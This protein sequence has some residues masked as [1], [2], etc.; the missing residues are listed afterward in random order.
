MVESS[1]AVANRYRVK[2]IPTLRFLLI[3]ACGSARLIAQPEPEASPPVEGPEVTASQVEILQALYNSIQAKEDEIDRLEQTLAESTNESSRERNA[4]MLNRSDAELAD[5]RQEFV[6]AATGVDV[7]LFVEEEAT[8]FSWEEQLGKLLQPVL[9]ELE[10]ATAESRALAELKEQQAQFEAQRAAA[11]QAEDTLEATLAKVTDEALKTALRQ[12]IT[13]WSQRRTIAENQVNAAQ[14]RIDRMEAVQA[15]LLD[16]S[17]GAIQSFVRTRGLNLLLAALAF[18]ATYFVT[19]MAFAAIRQGIASKKKGELPGRVLALIGQVLSAL[20]A[21]LAV[22]LVFNLRGD[23][24][25]LGIVLILLLGAAWASFKT[26]PGYVESVKLVLNLGT[27]RED[28]CLVFHGLPWKV[29]SLGFSCRLVNERLDGG[30]LRVPVKLLIGQLSRPMGETEQ[31]FPCQKGDWVTLADGRTGEVIAQNPTLVTL[32]ELGGAQCSYATADFL[33]QQPRNL[34]H[35]YRV[36]TRFG[37]DHAHQAIATTSVPQI[38]A[39]T[40]RQR[41]PQTL[42]TD[43][44]R[45][46]RVDFA[47]ATS[48]ALEY[49]VE[50]DLTG[51]AANFYEDAGFALQRILVEV[52]QEHQWKIPFTQL[53]LHQAH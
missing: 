4:A 7:S 25:L 6:E 52:C 17:T 24:F 19:K 43:A 32:R 37:I 28:E 2:L 34:S 3:L 5:L 10:D 35:G 48:S 45:R 49:E 44:I 1:A 41:L 20:L 33:K 22:I 16:S 12:Q 40:L 9:S 31:L 13:V 51:S 47:C 36:E 50:V 18:A 39:E 30:F 53:T 29:E 46:V 23:W 38:M 11:A 27:V 21:I 26:L 15:S 14:L 42:P 8:A